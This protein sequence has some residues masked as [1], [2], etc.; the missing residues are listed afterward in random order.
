MNQMYPKAKEGFLTKKVDLLADEIR[1]ALIDTGVAGFDAAHEFFSSVSAAVVG[2]PAVL[3]GKSVA[4][5]AFDA[6]DASFTGVSGSSVE[7]IVLYQWT[8]DAATSRLIL[9][10]DQATGL[11]FAPHGGTVL[12]PWDDGANKIFRI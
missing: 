10:I 9:W 8:G 7:A 6:A 12:V 2:T 1:V 11:P 3:S 4:D 5:G